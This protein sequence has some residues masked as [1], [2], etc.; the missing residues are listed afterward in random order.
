M[1]IKELQDALDEVEVKYDPKANKEELQKLYDDNV[2]EMDDDELNDDDEITD[3]KDDD[4]D[5]EKIVDDNVEEKPDEQETDYLRK[6][7]Y[8][9]EMP[10]GHPNTD[11]VCGS[12][13]ERMKA[14]LLAQPKVR[15]IV[16]KEQGEEG[17]TPLSVNLNGYRL[18][19]PKNVYIDVP[20]QIADLVVNSQQQK[21]NALNDPT[22][23][24]GNEKKENALL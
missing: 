24:D 17:T 19:L 12:K 14:H 20:E 18:D 15:I 1:T 8:G 11:P 23:I 13:A 10:V 22:R 2:E 7:Q 21:E 5:G 3:D 9:K 16:Q 6:Y 4:S